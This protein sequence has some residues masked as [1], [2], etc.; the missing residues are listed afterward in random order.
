MPKKGNGVGSSRPRR[1]VH[2]EDEAL[3]Q[4]NVRENRPIQRIIEQIHRTRQRIDELTEMMNATRSRWERRYI[5]RQRSHYDSQ[6]RQLEMEASELEENFRE[7]FPPI[8][9]L[10]DTTANHPIA[11]AR[12]LPIMPG[13]RP[14]NNRLFPHG[15][16]VQPITENN[17]DPNIVNATINPFMLYEPIPIPDQP[18]EMDENEMDE[19][20]INHQIYLL[21]NADNAD[22]SGTGLAKNVYLGNSKLK[23]TKNSRKV[24]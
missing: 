13:H 14:F 2:D 3:Y 10:G 5:A 22:M 21:N 16:R 20:Q 1:G 8:Q 17:Y 18:N 4:L 6:L 24:F 23:I 11:F 15:R 7:R 9:A 12:D 19:N